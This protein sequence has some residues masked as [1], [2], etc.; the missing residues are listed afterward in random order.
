M[1]DGAVSVTVGDTSAPAQQ[2]L[3]GEQNLWSLWSERRIDA[4]P[5]VI[6]PPALVD[7]SAE[8]SPATSADTSGVVAASNLTELGGQMGRGGAGANTGQGQSSDPRDPKTLVQ[9]PIVGEKFE[10]MV[11]TVDVMVATPDEGTSSVAPPRARA[12]SSAIREMIASKSGG[13]GTVGASQARI[14]L[15]VDGETIVIH[16]RLKDGVVDVDVSGLSQSELGRVRE[17]LQ[18]RLPQSG[19]DLGDMT[20]GREDDDV[21]EGDAQSAPVDEAEAPSE[22]ELGGAATMLNRAGRIWLR[23]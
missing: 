2:N 8:A 20:E 14:E 4:A 7:Q 1:M 16:V 21:S 22:D 6:Q 11:G 12:V 9:R 18:E 19:M 13:L 3:I 10:A 15:C 17:E 23:A 5:S